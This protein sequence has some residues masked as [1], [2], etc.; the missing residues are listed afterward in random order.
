MSKPLSEW[1]Q[2]EGKLVRTIT[3]SNFKEVISVVNKISKIAE[4][5]N[6]H[7]DLEI[8]SYRKLRIKIHTHELNK[9]TEKDFDRIVE[10]IQKARIT[11]RLGKRQKLELL[12]LI[13]KA[14]ATL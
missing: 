4:K 10:L 12:A 5:V 9:L 3:F 11:K 7:P 2:K 8:F 13:K 6:H 1:K 14:G